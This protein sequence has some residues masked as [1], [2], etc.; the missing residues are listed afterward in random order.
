VIEGELERSGPKIYVSRVVSGSRKNRAQQ[1]GARSG[2]SRSGRGT[3]SEDHRNG[4]AERQNSPLCSA[5]M[6]CTG[7]IE[8]VVRQ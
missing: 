3:V 2:R 1:S 8:S 7:E 4:N 5:P 6:L